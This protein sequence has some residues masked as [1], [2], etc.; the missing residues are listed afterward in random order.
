MGMNRIESAF[1]DPTLERPA[2]DYFVVR[3]EWDTFHVDEDNATKIIS[4][5][6]E[7]GGAKIVRCETIT[8]SVIFV[9]P[10]AV[11]FV[12]ECTKA[13]RE[14]ERRHWK[15]LDKEEESDLGTDE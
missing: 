1:R 12:R 7:V 8:G 15:R 6:T 4:A 9:R 3:L 11:L 14:S 13:Q 10:A 2:E 5:M